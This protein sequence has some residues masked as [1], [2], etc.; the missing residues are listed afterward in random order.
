MLVAIIREYPVTHP[1]GIAAEMQIGCMSILA[2]YQFTDAQLQCTKEDL[3]RLLEIGMHGFRSKR[4]LQLH[5]MHILRYCFEV[6]ANPA[7]FLELTRHDEKPWD[8]YD[9]A[10]TICSAWRS[11]LKELQIQR[12]VVYLFRRV[13]E[14]EGS[15]SMFMTVDTVVATCVATIKT[16]NTDHECT[17]NLIQLISNI[18]VNPQLVE[19][20]VAQGLLDYLFKML[21]V[22]EKDPT[23]IMTVFVIMKRF[24]AANSNNR[25]LILSAGA[26][27]IIQNI[28]NGFAS[29]PM[30]QQRGMEAINMLFQGV[31][32]D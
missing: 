3:M 12:D 25:D 11:Y 31:A 21:Q 18:S 29:E 13:S 7:V 5:G 28:V 26:A 6:G 17:T 19:A 8:R 1:A 23:I 24:V 4:D 2:K 32:V 22:W 15:M 20:M 10:G 14:L 30:V 9:K 16:H 27:Q